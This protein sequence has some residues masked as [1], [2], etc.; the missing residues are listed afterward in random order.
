MMTSASFLRDAAT[1]RLK[2]LHLGSM[3]MR[4]RKMLMRRQEECLA[5][6]YHAGFDD[7]CP[8]A[9]FFFDI[10]VTALILMRLIGDIVCRCR[11]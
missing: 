6:A 1:A 8:L 4:R 9:F 5:A 3:P 7:A 11:S 10:L 2:T